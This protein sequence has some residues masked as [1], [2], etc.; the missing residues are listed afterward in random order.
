M[1]NTISVVVRSNT[2]MND[3]T[4]TFVVHLHVQQMNRTANKKHDLLAVEMIYD[5]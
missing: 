2:L 3:K 1:K 5:S 4:V